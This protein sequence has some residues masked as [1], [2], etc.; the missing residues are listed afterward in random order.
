VSLTLTPNGEDLAAVFDI[1]GG[2]F[3]AAG[4]AKRASD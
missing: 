3:S 1:G 2:A 4:T